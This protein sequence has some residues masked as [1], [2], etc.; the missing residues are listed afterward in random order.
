MSYLGDALGYAGDALGFVGDTL[1]RPGAAVR[2]LLAG[3]PD[4]L[5]NLLPGSETMGLI[6]P[7]SKVSGR[8]LLRNYG[9]AGQDDNWG[10]YLGGL[11]VEAATDPLTYAGGYLAKKGVGAIT[12]AISDLRPAGSA[13]TTSALRGARGAFPIATD[14]MPNGALSLNTERMLDRASRNAAKGIADDGSRIYNVVGGGGG[15]ANSPA[16]PNVRSLARDLSSIPEYGGLYDKSRNA[17]AVMSGAGYPTLRHESI[18]GLVDQV[19]RGNAGPGLPLPIRVA[20]NLRA[21]ADGSLRSG[22]GMVAD[23]LA[24][25]MLENRGIGN[26]LKA[27]AEFLTSRSYPGRE[28][29][30]QVFNNTPYAGSIYKYAPIAGDVGKYGSYVGGSMGSRA[31]MDALGYNQ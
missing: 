14:V 22:A 1:G 18:H 24:A 5:L 21:G 9:I 6:D 19:A 27:G 20:G 25:Q 4:Q 2:G 8:D 12:N 10:N 3:R 17:G 30:Q 29:Y 31:L 23:E 26:Q 28:A 7:S 13:A 16:I 15:T 11:A